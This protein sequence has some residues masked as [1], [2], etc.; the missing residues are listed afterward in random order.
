[1]ALLQYRNTPLRGISKSTAGLAFGRQL[2]D[3]LPL[4]RKRYKIDSQWAHHLRERERLMPESSAEVK[5]KYDQRSRE[6][7]ELNQGDR[8]LCQ[9]VRSR[10]WDKSGVI[11]KVGK[12]RQYHVKMVGSGRISLRNR[13]HLQKMVSHDPR[14]VQVMGSQGNHLVNDTVQS[15]PT[16]V[17]ESKPPMIVTQSTN[18]SEEPRENQ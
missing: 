12:H 18:E 13:R 7:K 2:R 11:I 1:M 15:L 8:L 17:N 10:R 9:N 6:L 4:P 3:T 5:V 14:I 16:T